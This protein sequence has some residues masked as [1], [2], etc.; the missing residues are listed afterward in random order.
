[1]KS[2]TFQRVI[3]LAFAINT[4]VL[5]FQLVNM[6]TELEQYK[7]IAKDSVAALEVSTRNGSLAL[8]DL[9]RCTTAY[10]N[11]GQR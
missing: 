2:N 7:A 6:H 5:L 1:M 4:I 3:V 9:E 10:H 8:A 11:A